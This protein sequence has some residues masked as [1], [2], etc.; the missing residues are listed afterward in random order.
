MVIRGLSL[1]VCLSL[2]VSLCPSASL[3]VSLCLSV[4]LSLCLT[5]FVSVCVCVCVCVCLS[6]SLS[7]LH[8]LQLT[9]WVSMLVTSNL[10][11]VVS[12]LGV[13]GN[14]LYVA[15]FFRQRFRERVKSASS[16]WRWPT[17]SSALSTS[18]STGMGW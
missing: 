5:V 1:C 4:S 13:V 15:V 8:F 7:V 17:W 18:F 12:L 11:P 2:S 14:A 3:S 10:V 6:L 16:A 9:V